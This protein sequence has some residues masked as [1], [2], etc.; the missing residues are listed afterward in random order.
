M[1]DAERLDWLEAEIRRMANRGE[2]AR[3]V[4]L[5]WYSK[6][7]DVPDGYAVASGD[8]DVNP[9]EH[10]SLRAAIDAAATE[11]T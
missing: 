4:L 2:H 10:V 1:T 3:V 7:G 11:E 6:P 5:A 8:D 9:D